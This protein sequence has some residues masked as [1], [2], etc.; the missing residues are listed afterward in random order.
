[1]KNFISEGKTFTFTA[2]VGGVTSGDVLSIGGVTV[3][4]HEDA[5]A[6]A[7]FVGLTCG[8]F[9]LPTA[10]TPTE[11]ALAYIT[12]A[13]LIVSTAS[14]NTKVGAFVSVKDADGNADVWL[15]GI[16]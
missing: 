6:G 3:V 12:S 4:A 15:P 10:S 9:S 16:V 1:M 7:D 8:V 11:G 5:E 13:G 14:G 2:P